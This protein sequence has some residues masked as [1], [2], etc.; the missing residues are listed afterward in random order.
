[1]SAPINHFKRAIQSGEQQIGLWL[2]M[3]SPNS[4][5]LLAHVG[6]DWLLIDLEHAPNDLPLVVNQLQ[7]I[8]TSQC[9]AVV[10]PPIGEAWMI[11]QILDTGCQTILVPMVE[12][13]DQAKELVRAVRYPPHGIRGVGAGLAR[14]SL[15]GTNVADYLKSADEQVCLL[16]QVESTSGLKALDDI[17]KVEGVDG[18]FIGPADLA[19]DMGHLGNP[20]APPVLAAIEKALSSIKAAGVAS[21]ILSSDPQMLA[22][23]SELDTSFIAIG[24]D[25][26]LLRGAAEAALRTIALRHTA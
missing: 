5:E 19:A 12:S 13:A 25:V 20:N 4:A 26:G 15:Y 3:A 18:I 2:A 6:F 8:A 16:L 22:R 11:K 24:S 7:A 14:A 1:M 17:L 10:R 23:A 9:N 21:G